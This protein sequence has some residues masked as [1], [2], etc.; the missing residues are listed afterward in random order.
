MHS[1]L[2]KISNI[3]ICLIPALFIIGPAAV[4]ISTFIINFIFLFY[5]FK[6]KEYKYFKN[7]FFFIF[8]LFYIFLV[9]SSLLSEDKILSLKTSLP[10]IRWGIFI[11]AINFFLNNNQNLLK[12]FF[13]FLIVVITILT[14]DGFFQYFYDQNLLGFKRIVS[15][16]LSGFFRDELII[17]ISLLKL[18]LIL[19][20]LFFIFNKNFNY[21]FLFTLLIVFINLLIFLSGERA[22]AFL[23]L[24]STLLFLILIRVSFVRKILI[25]IVSTV[26]I[27]VF[28]FFD[29]NTKNRMVDHTLQQTLKINKI[30]ALEKYSYFNIFSPQHEK[31]IISAYLIYKNNNITHKIF[32]S[33]PRMF[34]KLCLRVENCDFNPEQCCSTHPHNIFMQFLSELGIIG[35]I[36]LMIFYF[37]IIFKMVK[38]FLKKTYELM[39]NAK[40]VLLIAMFIN[41]FPLLTSGNFFNNRFSYLNFLFFAL[42]LYIDHT[43]KHNVK[44]RNN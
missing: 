40:L 4:E 35:I 23:L 7:Y 6:N 33:G 13:Y 2:F 28:Y 43:G 5:I 10:Y 36:F 27:F 1:Y 32:G 34:S 44:I 8:I 9:T 25:V 18:M 31:H 17:G 21:K 12:V 38:I 26:L 39:D 24:I 42:Y 30:N 11:L 41:F 29:T 20:S 15:H 3:T 37:I 16:R 14:L 19:I 22:S